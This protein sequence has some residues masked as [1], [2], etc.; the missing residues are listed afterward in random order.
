MDNISV[1]FPIGSRVRSMQGC[2]I[3]R[4]SGYRPEGEVIGY[5]TW[6]GHDTV[7]IK[8]DDG[9]KVQLLHWNVSRMPD[10]KPTAVTYRFVQDF[11]KDP[12]GMLI[13][14]GMPRLEVVR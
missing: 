5:G 11:S 8:R 6:A 14:V 2:R 4:K 10:K 1:H 7:K 13:M 9:K 12:D 3:A